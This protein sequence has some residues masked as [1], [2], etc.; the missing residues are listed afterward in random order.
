MESPTSTTSFED[1]SDAANEHEE[2]IAPKWWETEVRRELESSSSLADIQLICRYVPVNNPNTAIQALSKQPRSRL[3]TLCKST[4]LKYNCKWSS[5]QVAEAIVRSALERKETPILLDSRRSWSPP[6]STTPASP[7]NIAGS[8]NRHFRYLIKNVCLRDWIAAALGYT[9]N[10]I[11]SLL[12]EYSNT[13]EMLHQ[14]YK[15]K[16]LRKKTR[17]MVEEVRSLSCFQF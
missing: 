3:K 12:E 6:N 7:E 9:T 14:W 16:S 8:L 17:R 15:Q 4:C 11:P 5:S 2:E 1:I 10:A 13:R